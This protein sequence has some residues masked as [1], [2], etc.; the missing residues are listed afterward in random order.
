VKVVS[1]T[2][3]MLSKPIYLSKIEDSGI[4]CVE[5]KFTDIV[6]WPPRLAEGL[7]L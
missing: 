2:G 6:R 7:F 3:G 4:S 5:I 1:S